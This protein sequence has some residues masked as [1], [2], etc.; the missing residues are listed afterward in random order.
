MLRR[1]RAAPEG[2]V[3]GSVV[4]LLTPGSSTRQLIF[5]ARREGPRKI[6]VSNCQSQD[7]DRIS[8]RRE[9]TKILWQP[10][11]RLYLLWMKLTL[12]KMRKLNRESSCPTNRTIGSLSFGLFLETPLP[13]IDRLTRSSS[14]ASSDIVLI[15]ARSKDEE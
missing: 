8:R 6:G 10:A 14:D 5:A 4:E 1:H 15:L 11:S 9:K 13:F 12:Q 3:M 7:H 2:L